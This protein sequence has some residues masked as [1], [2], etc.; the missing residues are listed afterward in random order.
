MKFTATYLLLTF[1]IITP[2]QLSAQTTETLTNES[3]IQLT[4]SGLSEDAIIAKI[5][6][7]KINFDTSTKAITDLKTSGVSDSVIVQMLKGNSADETEKTDISKALVE[8][9]IVIPDGTEVIVQLK[10]VLS[11]Q[12]SKVGDIIDLVV[13]QDVLID[14]VKVIAQGASATARITVAKKAGYWGKKGQL[15]WTMQDIQTVEGKI[16]ARFTKK[17][18]G[19]SNSGTVAVGAVVTTVLLGPIGLLWGLKKGKAAEIPAGTKFSVFTDNEAKIKV[20]I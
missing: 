1:L 13:A 11:G 4:K 6:G 2:I 17:T 9:E 5:K 18:D 8:K 20:K 15:E 7:S 3:I 12:D 14:G 10:Y 19:K 16:P